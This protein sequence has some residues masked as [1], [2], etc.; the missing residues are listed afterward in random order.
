MQIIRMK[1]GDTLELRCTND[2]TAKTIDKPQILEIL[3][4]KAGALLGRPVRATVVDLSARPSANP[5]M[6]ELLRFGREHS[7]VIKI[8]K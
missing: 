5:R 8:K 1:V 4:R 3:S 7:D 2:F 6:E